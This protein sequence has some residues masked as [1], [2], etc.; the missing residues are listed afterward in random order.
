MGIGKFT[1]GGGWGWWVVQ[2]GWVV[3]GAFTDFIAVKHSGECVGD[4]MGIPTLRLTAWVKSNPLGLILNILRLLVLLF[5]KFGSFGSVFTF[6]NL[7]STIFKL[8]GLISIM[9][10]IFELPVLIPLESL[11]LTVLL[12]SFVHLGVQS[13]AGPAILKFH[14]LPV[15][16]KV[17]GSWVVIVVIKVIRQMGTVTITIDGIL[18]VVVSTWSVVAVLMVIGQMGRLGDRMVD[19][20]VGL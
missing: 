8:P 19:M 4:G 7:I 16:V 6:T 1:I 10:S 20:R 14:I 2:G 13:C 11:M 15:V 5:L 17:R 12:F 9:F 3:H 18:I